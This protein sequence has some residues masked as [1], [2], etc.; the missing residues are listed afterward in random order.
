MPSYWIVVPLH[1]LKLIDTEAPVGGFLAR[2]WTLAGRLQMPLLDSVARDGESLRG[3]LAMIRERL[4]PD[5]LLLYWFEDVIDAWRV[6]D[7][8]DDAES[9][10][11]A[12]NIASLLAERAPGPPWEEEPAPI[13][14]ARFKEHFDL[15]LAL[16][17][18]RLWLSGHSTGISW[19]SVGDHGGVPKYSTETL[20]RQVAIAPPVVGRALRR[21]EQPNELQQELECSMRALAAAFQST[22]VGQFIA[23]A[24]S[25]VESL[26]GDTW[27]KRVG[28][29][30]AL[31]DNPYHARLDEVIAARH[32]FVH[33]ARQPPLRDS[34]LAQAAL[35]IVIQ[36][37]AK[38]ALLPQSI[39]TKQDL[40]DIV[41]TVGQP[42]MR[43]L[44]EGPD[45]RLTWVHKYLESTHPNEYHMRFVVNE[46]VNCPGSNCGRLLG[47]EGVIARNAMKW[48][49]HCPHCDTRFDAVLRS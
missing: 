5:A 28:R 20:M 33:A 22:S 36:A 2:P 1:G 7:T 34:F 26:L 15:P 19:A 27:K 48:T 13:F 9:I 11:G 32:E 42:Q 3:N 25:S 38:I 39:E 12:L 16:D 37:W 8:Y 45:S 46:H 35:A 14:R 4:N 23:S 24:I 21:E 17:S 30:R 41:R 31:L 10:V 40:W 29:L 44:P 47:T 18:E 43:P 49:I 6:F